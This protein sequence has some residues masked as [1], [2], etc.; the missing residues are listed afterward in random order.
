MSASG[1][2]VSTGSAYSTPGQ[3]YFGSNG[4]TTGTT[5]FINGYMRRFTIYD[6][7]MPDDK[8]QLISKV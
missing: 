2:S 1:S 7:K 6:Y 8:L 5:Y 4:G 3:M